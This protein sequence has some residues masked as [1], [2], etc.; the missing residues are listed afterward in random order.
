MQIYLPIAELSV[1]AMVLLGLGG[2][3]GLLPGVLG[4][5]GGFLITPL[6]FFLRLPPAGAAGAG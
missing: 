4:G 2:V 5:G 1:N 3:V 6:L